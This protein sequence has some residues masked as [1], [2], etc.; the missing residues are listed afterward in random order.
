MSAKT[1][2]RLLSSVLFFSNFS[3]LAA[4]SMAS[5]NDAVVFCIV[6]VLRFYFSPVRKSDLA[7][8][9]ITILRVA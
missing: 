2:I 3:Y 9:S 7:V 5:L 6:N 1:A 8:M 4:S